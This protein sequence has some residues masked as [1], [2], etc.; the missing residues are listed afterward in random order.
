MILSV[1][2]AMRILSVLSDAKNQP[3]TLTVIAAKT[4][5][6][7]PTC[8]HILETLCHDGYAV[9]VS[10]S[11]GYTPGPAL[12][13]LTRYGRY[14]EE[15]VALCRPV[16]RWM[17][18][19][20]H[21]TVILSVIQSRN[22]FIIDFADSEQN[23]LAEHTHIR[24][25]DIYR[26]ATGRAILAHSD[27]ETV[28][29]VYQKYGAP[30]QS[31]W[32]GISSPED[33]DEAL[34]ALRH[35]EIVTS[36]LENDIILHRNIGLACPLFRKKTCIGALGLA[37]KTEEGQLTIDPTVKENLYLVLK[38]GTRE[39]HRRLAYEDSIK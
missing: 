33:L 28:R 35:Q 2:K 31:D 17:E 23:L 32:Q 27:R 3:V 15:L 12:Y 16:M 20:S 11:R 1:Q 36:G 37:W 24:T 26:T 38:R 34:D 13:C 14:E 30:S 8:A 19:R 29:D 6:P 10:H 25:D 7:P 39:I 22:K 21:A 4:G 5:F 9:R 18:R